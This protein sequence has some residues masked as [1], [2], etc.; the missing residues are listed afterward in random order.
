MFCEACQDIFSTPRKLSY[1]TY[2]PW[3]QTHASFR[4]A[5]D[6]GCHLCS[7][8]DESRSYHGA[9]ADGF[10]TEIKYAFKALNP[11]WARDGEGMKWLVPQTSDSS[12][13][14]PENF[15]TELSVYL[16]EVEMDPTP[17]NLGKLLAL[18]AVEVV[19][20]INKFWLVL[21]LYGPGV[22]IVLPMEIATGKF[23]LVHGTRCNH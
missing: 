21:E 8:I 13:W 9:P 16:R 17:N 12:C 2:Y 23:A 20:A 18:D 6:A 11:D 15:E 7:I 3:K 10:P 1:G 14:E 4:A 19:D 5:L 22:Q